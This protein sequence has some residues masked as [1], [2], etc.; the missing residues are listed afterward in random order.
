MKSQ[1]QRFS[2]RNAFFRAFVR[3]SAAPALLAALAGQ[4][5]AQNALG[6][7]RGLDRNLLSGSAGRNAAGT[8]IASELRFRN[9]LVTGNVPAGFSFRGDVGYRAPDDFTAATG[10]NE[11]FDFQ[12]DSLYSA[13]GRLNPTLRNVDALRYQMRL[14]TGGQT[15]DAWGLPIVNRPAAG[16]TVGRYRAQ[17]AAEQ[18]DFTNLGF[19]PFELR[20]G[21]L[22]SVSNYITT[23]ALAPRVLAQGEGQTPEGKPITMFAVA[24]PLRGVAMQERPDYMRPVSENLRAANRV[25]GLLS[26]LAQAP[27]AVSD[28]VEPGRALY[29]QILDRLRNPL[30][31]GDDVEKPGAHP[32]G[33]RPVEADDPM[34]KARSG[35]LPQPAGSED[36]APAPQQGTPPGAPGAPGGP[37]AGQASGGAVG[38]LT[39]E[40]R[41]EQISKGLELSAPVERKNKSDF[42]PEAPKSLEE[43]VAEAKN[44]LGEAPPK[45]AT[46]AP[47]TLS[48]EAI[49]SDHMQRG[50]QRLAEQR[51]FDAEESFTAALRIAPGDPI[52]AIGRVNAQIGAGMFLSAAVNLQQLFRGYPEMI[53]IRYDEKLLPRTERLTR[54]R[55]QL[56]DRI[57]ESTELGRS[58]AILLAY[59][60][61]QYGDTQDMN[62]AF[63]AIKRI[64]RDRGDLADPLYEVLEAVW[65]GSEA[66]PAK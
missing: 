34:L 38:N 9:A 42:A 1:F 2:R 3:F 53:N 15:D 52:A 13:L 27:T 12:R 25:S 64:T 51:W 65:M 59:L 29:D 50:Q 43:L 6:D 21:A 54:I 58:S 14:S 48:S 30:E 36:E 44:V 19:D 31:T 7:G 26:D 56:R 39:I 63:R 37:G 28:R 61:Y 60:G 4:A 47:P 8:D 18:G 32:P 46:L 57:L 23:Q 16:E 20:P 49:L 10:T 22:R 17:Q 33:S 55:E 40:Q 24:T 45:V 41:L 62:D 66:A 35:L 11:I 5:A